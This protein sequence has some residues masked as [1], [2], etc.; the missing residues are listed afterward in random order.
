MSP[1]AIDRVIDGRYRV[2]VHLAEGG[3]ASVYRATDLRLDR[4]VALKVMRPDLARDADFVSRFRREAQA[5]ARLSHPH[6]VSVFDQGEDDDVVFLA[7]ELVEG[8]TL[9]DVVATQAPL[10]VRRATEIV[11]EILQALSAAHRAGIAH[12]DIKP[13]NVLMSATGTVKVADFG[14]ARAITAGSMSRT[15]DLLWGTAAYLS[16]E[17]VEHGRSDERTDVYAV[18]LLLYELLTGVKAFPGQSPIQVAYAHVHGEVPRAVDTVAGLPAE[19]DVVI[20]AA[21]ATDPRGRPGDAA[22]LRRELRRGIG[23]LSEEEL[24]HRPTRPERSGATAAAQA[25]GQA[26]AT[27]AVHQPTAVVPLTPAGSRVRTESHFART[28][29][30]RKPAAASAPA[31]PASE[32]RPARPARAT[33]T[34]ASRRAR[35][36]RRRRMGLTGV[37]VLLLL[38]IGGGGAAA[39]WYYT[40]GPGVHS[41]VPPLVGLTEQEAVTALETEDL[42]AVSVAAF[43][44]TVPTGLVL[45]SSQEAGASLRHGAEV[46]ITVSQ[47]PER[48]AVPTDLVGD[49]L[50]EAQTA[51]EEA[52]LTLGET[53]EKFDEEVPE[54]QVLSVSPAPG[55]QLKPDTPVD[56]VLSAGREP[57]EVPEVEGA[58]QEQATSR[59]E[60][61]GFTVQVESERVFDK[62]VPA[63]SVTAQVP[64]RGTGFR[65]DQVTL[66][67]SKGPE[68]VQVPQVIGMPWKQAQP[69]LKDLG[70]KVKREDIAGAFFGTVRFQSIDSGE[71]V[72]VGT[73]IVI[74]VL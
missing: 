38:V 20:A 53:S 23:Q 35:P 9:R 68:L 58:T 5:A 43:S 65:G 55:E 40:N 1:P 22:A 7:M 61:A 54:G 10:S 6:V 12:R 70:L 50:E 74:S 8:D 45:A 42:D 19:M 26:D 34:P 69:L 32:A 63:G 15:S 44:E 2:E 30:N 47:G 66:T 17:Q 46:E 41:P 13:E 27:V 49:T 62:D 37:L 14:L 33:P 24:D 18:G 60:G 48:H 39:T 73:E 28:T 71:Q 11:D 59:L 21:T 57:I 64:A 67:V 29:G 31:V 72:P 25:P 52:S 3:M 4:P 16:P 36:R 56:L 51:L